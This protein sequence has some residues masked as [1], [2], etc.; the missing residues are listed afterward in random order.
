MT[1]PFLAETDPAPFPGVTYIPPSPLETQEPIVGNPTD[2]NLFHLLGNLSPYF[3]SPG[4]GA[5]EYPL[6][7]GSEI[8]W[9]NMLSRHGSRYP[10]SRITLGDAIRAT[11]GAN[12]TGDLAWLNTWRYSLGTNILNPIGRQE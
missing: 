7:E 11:K 10:T 3:P 6:P 12:F 4:F 9:L 5:D 2:G 8:V 1:E